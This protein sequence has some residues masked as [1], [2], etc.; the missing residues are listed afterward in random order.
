MTTLRGAAQRLIDLQDMDRVEIIRQFG[1]ND[2]WLI[3]CR[4][5]RD[6]LRAT[7]AQEPETVD[8]RVVPLVESALQAVAEKMGDQCAVWYGI[9]ARDVEAVLREAARYGLVHG[10]LAEPLQEDAALSAALGWPGGISDPVLD[11][12]SLL[13]MV[14]TLS[15]QK[16][17]EGMAHQMRCWCEDCDVKAH[18]GLRTKM[19]VCP[20]CGDKRCSRAAH[21]G[22]PCSKKPSGPGEPPARSGSVFG[23]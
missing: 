15:R 13:Q 23:G 10:A 4:R 17:V 14:T 2:D 8:Q 18:G 16:D 12:T 20:E 6:V 9:G 21:H 22:F 19:S 1:H 11:R 7:L 3:A 5:A